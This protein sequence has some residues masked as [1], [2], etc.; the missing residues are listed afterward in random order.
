MELKTK[1]VF[2][3]VPTSGKIIFDSSRITAIAEIHL[4]VHDKITAVML[5]KP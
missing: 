4:L 2:T 1:A 5:C 3:I